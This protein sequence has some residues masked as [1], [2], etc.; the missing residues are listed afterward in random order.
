[1]TVAQ[2][3][4]IIGCSVRHVRTMICRGRIGA[5]SDG[6]RYF[7]SSG[8]VRR[9]LREHPSG[10]GFPRGAKRIGPRGKKVE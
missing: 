1:M 10:R 3:A 4:E 7:V 6:R 9:F 2:A 5:S 8:E